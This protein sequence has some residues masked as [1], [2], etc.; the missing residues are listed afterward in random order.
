[1]R[2][3]QRGER[4]ILSTGF[5]GLVVFLVYFTAFSPWLIQ[6]ID[7]HPALEIAVTLLWVTV[8]AYACRRVVQ[9]LLRLCGLG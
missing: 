8:A 5:F 9:G 7:D 1:M 6:V 2:R 3:C 4:Q